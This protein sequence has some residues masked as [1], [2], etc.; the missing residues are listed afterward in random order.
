MT[1]SGDVLNIS[2]HEGNREVGSGEGEGASQPVTKFRRLL[3]RSEW[4]TMQQV[5]AWFEHLIT[6]VQNPSGP[7]AYANQ[8]R[9]TL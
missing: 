6:N 3:L 9:P 7:N 8:D 1:Q 4:T 2:K 5:I